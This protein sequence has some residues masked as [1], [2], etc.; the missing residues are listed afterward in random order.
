MVGAIEYMP[1]LATTKVGKYYRTPVPREI[2]KLLDISENDE[3]E[4]V[5]ENNKVIIR[6]K[7]ER[8]D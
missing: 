7:G 8:Y 4:W 2:R 5:F 6:K 1:V 3:I